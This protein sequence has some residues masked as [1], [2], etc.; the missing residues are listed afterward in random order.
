MVRAFSLIELVA[1]VAISAVV[2]AVAVGLTVRTSQGLNN[3]TAQMAVLEFIQRERNS[4][5]NRAV[6]TDVVVF[7]SAVG[8]GD[9]AGTPGD[10]IVAYRAP[11]PVVFP[12]PPA[13][14]LGRV[15]FAGN[16]FTFAPAP[17]LFVDAFA[18]SVDDVGNPRNSVL[19]LALRGENEDIVFRADGVAVPSFDAQSAVVVAPHVA[20]VGTR[21]TTNPTPQ[22]VPNTSFR[23]RRV[24][25]E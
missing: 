16:T 20:D 10:S 2:S 3:A 15:S 11:L 9:C 4:H 5:V 19:T 24:F 6:E 25:L 14:E 12:P 17:A 8:G 1:V 22:A 13:N 23:A 7:C 18:R 21:T